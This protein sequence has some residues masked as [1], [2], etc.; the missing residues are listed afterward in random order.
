MSKHT[1]IFGFDEQLARWACDRI[2]WADYNSTMKAVGVADGDDA[3]AQLMAVCVYHNYMQPKQV[4]GQTWYNSVEI[5]FASVNPAW[6]TRRTIRNLLKI[7]FHQYK[8]EQVFVVVPSINKPALEFVK[9]IGF[10]SRGMVSRFYSASI[11]AYVFGLHRN[12]F[13]SPDFLKRKITVQKNRRPHGQ[14]HAVSAASA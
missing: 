11:H 4:R 5:S 12:L 7:P 2:P 9:G 14:I 6:A 3:S 1:L 10:T 8:V 13:N